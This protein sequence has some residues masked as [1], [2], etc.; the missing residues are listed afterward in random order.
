MGFNFT[1]AVHLF[2]IY[3]G[4]CTGYPLQACTRIRVRTFISIIPLIYCSC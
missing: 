2:G 4:T 1:E 3:S